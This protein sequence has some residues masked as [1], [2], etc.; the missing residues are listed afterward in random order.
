MFKINKIKSRKYFILPVFFLC[1][2]T[3]GILIDSKIIIAQIKSIYNQN[4]DEVAGMS[5]LISAVAVNDV[6]GA[7]FF[8]KAGP[9]L[10]NQRNIGG[11][12]ALHIAS[13][14]KNLEIATL[15]IVN[16]ADVNIADNEGWTPLMRSSLAGSSEIVEL[17]LLK[18]ADAAA[19]NSV[20]ESAI[21][22]AATSDCD[23][24]LRAM[25]EKFNF[26]KNM[27]ETVLKSQISDAFVIAKNH[28][29]QK[30]Q[31]ILEKYLDQI[32]KMSALNNRVT[33]EF[34]A[35]SISNETP[36]NLVTKN[37][38]SFVEKDLSP[39]GK[40]IE[41]KQIGKIKSKFRFVSQ[42]SSEDQSDYSAYQV[43]KNPNQ[44]SK[45]KFSKKSGLSINEG[46]KFKI[47]E[48]IPAKEFKPNDS[49]QVFL[50]NSKIGNKEVTEILKSKKFK[51]LQ[52]PKSNQNQVKDLEVKKNIE[53]FTDKQNQK[54]AAQSTAEDIAPIPAVV[55]SFKFSQG[56]KGIIIDDKKVKQG[57]AIKNTSSNDN[58]SE[59]I[60]IPAYTKT[61]KAFKFSQGPRPI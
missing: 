13:R 33:E 22:H 19:L 26:I 59:A 60:A 27:E 49:N 48:K 50:R 44:P 46:N 28:D 23:Q 7:R 56:P 5:S 31:D 36:L 39:D 51:F 29:N 61:K 15:L 24:C 21:I 18:N 52:G 17:L 11:A 6:N 45:I 35:V 14:E 42:G 57:K 40:I 58:Y 9:A 34:G 8:S 32:V 43:S 54:A 16:G 41:K 38:G 1:V 47:E 37:K 10:V 4:S 2:C 53:D 12:T 30:I 55:N 20:N 3:F 25:F